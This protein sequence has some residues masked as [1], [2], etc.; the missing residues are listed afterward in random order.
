MTIVLNTFDFDNLGTLAEVAN[1]LRNQGFFIKVISNFG[2]AH[3]F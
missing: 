1:L 2:H 3:K